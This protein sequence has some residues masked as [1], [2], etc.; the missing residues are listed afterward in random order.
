MFDIGW[1]ELVLI[2]AVALIVVGPK[3]LPDMF[4]QIGRF[5]AKAKSM[6][7]EFSHA[8]E[9]AAKESGVH[10]VAGDLR[11][12]TS[13]KAMGIDAVRNAATKFESWDPLKSS[14]DAS[15][16]KAVEAAEIRHSAA[17]VTAAPVMPPPPPAPAPVA[18]PAVVRTRPK[19]VR[20]RV[21]FTEPPRRR[22]V[23]RRPTPKK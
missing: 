10:D 6:A 17:S 12:V 15:V 8:M 3:D 19:T 23:P 9:D 7:R 16:K 5:T 11:K 18:Q 1:S 4:R 20:R 21:M 14:R 13:P 22:A 2:G